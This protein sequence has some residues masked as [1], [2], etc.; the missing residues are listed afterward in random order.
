L[1]TYGW[2]ELYDPEEEID[3]KTLLEITLFL[4]VMLRSAGAKKAVTTIAQALA[5][6][7]AKR[8]PRA[9]LTRYAVYNIAKQVFKWVGISVTK[10]SF[11]RGVSKVIPV[12]GGVISG[13]VTLVT[14]PPMAKRLKEYLRSLPLAQPGAAD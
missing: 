8:L 5:R 11:A 9:A 12:F 7:T 3:D 4:G 6:E 2:P 10:T 14:L 1:Y 13:G